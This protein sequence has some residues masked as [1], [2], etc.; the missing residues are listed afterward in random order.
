MKSLYDKAH[1]ALDTAEKVDR[2]LESSLADALYIAAEQKVGLDVEK[3]KI[4]ID[5][6]IK[7]ATLRT[8][9]TSR[10]QS[11]IA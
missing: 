2:I 4:Q 7:L 8:Q 9:K 11:E 10:K 5:W 1:Q 6:W 3:Q